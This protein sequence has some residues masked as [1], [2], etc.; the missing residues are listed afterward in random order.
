M[1]LAE[2]IRDGI[3]LPFEK[4][5]RA[6]ELHNEIVR[7]VLTGFH[8]EII[9]TRKGKKCEIILE[10]NLVNLQLSISR[11]STEFSQNIISDNTVVEV[12]LWKLFLNDSTILFLNSLFS[13]LNFVRSQK[14]IYLY[15]QIS[16]NQNR[17]QKRT[18]M[19][20]MLL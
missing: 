2:F 8:M 20:K 19:E 18:K 1:L 11:L 9:Y 14:F 16:S 12:V 10:T 17:Q 7:C 4:R 5:V 3:H 13:T 6:I 15:F